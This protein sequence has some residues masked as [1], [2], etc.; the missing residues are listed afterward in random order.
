MK[1][2]I[3][4]CCILLLLAGCSSDE[5]KE[6]SFPKK[7]TILF[8]EYVIPHTF[9]PKTLDL[10]GLGD[11]L[12]QGVGDSLKLNGYIGRLQQE[13]LEYKGIEEVVLTN[14]AKRGRRSDQLLKM[15]K[16]GDI[17]H[18]LRRADIITITI[19]GNDMMKVFKK[20][21]FN[22]KIEAFEK[23]LL[24]FESNYDKILEEIREINSSAPVVLIGI[25]NP[26]TIVTD[27]TSEIDQIVTDWNDTI[28]SLSY[29]NINACYAPIDTLF[30]TNENLVYHTDFFHPNSKG[31]E[32]IADSIIDS[33]E[34]CG[35]IDK[36]NRELFF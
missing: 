27:E 12:T 17:D 34:N 28:E 23:E 4:I 29:S 25:Y 21:L 36:D 8:E 9:F 5:I 10:I 35:L 2:L 30:D 32:L 18:H 13:I 11:S 3:Q 33:L 24:R 14:T 26:V 1:H 19:G 7:E 31:Y 6:V 22:L 16:D 15:L 20:D